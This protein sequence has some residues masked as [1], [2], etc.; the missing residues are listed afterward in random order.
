MIVDAHVHVWGPGYL[1]QAFHAATANRWAYGVWPHRDPAAMFPKIEPGLMDPDAS[2]LMGDFDRAGIDAGVCIAVDFSYA[3]GEEAA[4][5]PE[6]ILRNF[7]DLQEKHHGRFYAFAGVDPRRPGGLALVRRAIADWGLKGF[8]VHPPTGFYP[9][10]PM[11]FPFYETCLDLGVPVMFHTAMSP[12]PLRGYF[13]NPL[14]LAEVQHRFP[15]MTIVFGHAGH[16]FWWEQ[17]AETVAGHPTSYLEISQWNYIVDKE[18][19][20]VARRLARCRDLVGAQRILLGSDHFSGTRFSGDRS[21]LPRWVGFLRDLPRT[22]GQYGVR[23][24]EEEM[25]LILGGNAQRILKIP[26]RPAAGR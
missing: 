25:A 7:A 12:Y 18:P 14:Y 23:F 20:E 8:K 17:A 10:D 11:C 24:T 6:A 19:G 3:M 16:P 13:A 1:P 5:P 2:L 15:G 4:A 26:D 21:Q 22:G 9:H